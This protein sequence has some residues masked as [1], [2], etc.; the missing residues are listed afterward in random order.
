MQEVSK[1]HYRESGL[2]NVWLAGGVARTE[3]TACGK[4]SVRI[5]KEPQLLQVIALDLLMRPTPRTGAE[6]RFVRRACGLSQAALAHLLKSPR[7]ETVAEREGKEVTSLN[8]AE[9]VGLRWVLLQ[10][11]HDHLTTPGNSAL[12]AGQLERLWRFS[13]FF[14]EF[15]ARAEVRPRADKITARVHQ[16]AWTVETKKAA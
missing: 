11:F 1:Y 9:E 3:C 13:V 7:R 8:F 6:L 15:A 4:T 5:T 10:A 12:E 14:R 16:N 2:S